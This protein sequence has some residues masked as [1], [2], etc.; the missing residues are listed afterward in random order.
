MTDVRSHWEGHMCMITTRCPRT[1]REIATGID[2]DPD[3]FKNLPDVL[4][5]LSCPA[6]GEE[7]FWRTS[8]AWLSL[9]PPRTGAA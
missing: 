2:T 3:T 8:E 1:W 6:C 9:E 5:R 4:A 7:H